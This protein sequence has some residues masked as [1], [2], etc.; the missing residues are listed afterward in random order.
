MSFNSRN[1]YET[2]IVHRDTVRIR[3]HIP[4]IKNQY[5]T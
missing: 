5:N 2:G 4:N 3:D 1:Y